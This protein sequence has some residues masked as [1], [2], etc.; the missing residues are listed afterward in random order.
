MELFTDILE[1]LKTLT[2]V[3]YVF[4]AAI[5]LLLIL[6][7]TL[8]YFIKINEEV[9]NIEVKEKT[10][11]EKLSETLSKEQ[12]PRVV[13]MTT[14]EKEQEDRAIISYEELVKNSKNYDINYSEEKNI[15]GISIKKIDLNGEKLINKSTIDIRVV[16]YKKEEEFLS[17]LKNLQTL[18]N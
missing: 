18:L 5:I 10:E 2:F 13:N 3:D 9:L 11:L 14:F 15:D 1:F 7:I 4:F 17:M 16:S 6:I 12:K 8:I